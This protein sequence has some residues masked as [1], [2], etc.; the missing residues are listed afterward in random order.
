MSIISDIYDFPLRVRFSISGNKEQHQTFEEFC[1]A[2]REKPRNLVL[3]KAQDRPFPIRYDDVLVRLKGVPRYYPDNDGNSN[4]SQ[5]ENEKGYPFSIIKPDIKIV[6]KIEPVELDLLKQKDIQAKF[7]K[8]RL[9]EQ[10]NAAKKQEQEAKKQA[11]VAKKK[12]KQEQ[13]KSA[14]KLEKEQAKVTKRAERELALHN[15]TKNEQQ[16]ELEY[17]L[18]IAYIRPDDVIYRRDDV[19]VKMKN[20]HRFYPKDFD[21]E[22]Q[23]ISVVQ[24]DDTGSLLSPEIKII[25]KIELDTLNVKTRPNKK[26]KRQLKMERKKRALQSGMKIEKERKK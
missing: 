22:K 24:L 13:E 15:P 25:D 10:I 14:R 26:S 9:K 12:E 6:G 1:K 11:N 16:I 21:K 17:P 8:E 19:L 2:Q 23:P 18:Q 5:T 3:I 7:S 20:V 4:L